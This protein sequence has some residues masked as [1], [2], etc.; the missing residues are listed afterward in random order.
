M[1]AGIPPHMMPPGPSH[2]GAGA[3]P[4]GQMGG[5][6]MTP[7][8]PQLPPVLTAPPTPSY[9]FPPSSEEDRQKMQAYEQWL[10]QNEQNIGAQLKHYDEAIAKLRKH[11]KVSLYSTTT[12]S[13][14][15]ISFRRIGQFHWCA[16]KAGFLFGHCVKLRKHK[17]VSFMQ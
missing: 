10:N 7:P 12:V 5:H 9:N 1:G 8:A 4:G 16:S 13:L 3:G 11:K 6:R 17:K 15:Y 14:C 2:L